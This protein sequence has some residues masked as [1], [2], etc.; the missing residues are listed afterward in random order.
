MKDL[1][2]HGEVGEREHLG[3]DAQR[4]ELKKLMK[5]D[6]ELSSSHLL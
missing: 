4:L 3:G 2:L 5:A 1:G 6:R